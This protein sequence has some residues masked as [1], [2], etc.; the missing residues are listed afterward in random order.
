MKKLKKAFEDNPM[1][2][3]YVSIAAAT[4]VGAL[5]GGTA[6]L[7]EASAYAYRASKL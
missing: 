4:A 5:M 7:I 1:L 3:I 2:V 6:K